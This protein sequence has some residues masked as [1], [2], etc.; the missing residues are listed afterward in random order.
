MNNLDRVRKLPWRRLLA[1]L[2][3]M[4]LRSQPA[5][6]AVQDEDASA[7]R[8]VSTWGGSASA[9][10]SPGDSRDMAEL[11]MFVGESRVFPAPGVAR[12]AVGSGAILTAAAMDGKDV[13]LFANATGS[14]TLFIWSEN[15]INQKIKVTVTAGDITRVARDIS[16]FVSG[17]PKVRTSIIGDKVIIEG[18]DLSD[19]DLSKIDALA[20]MYPQVVN[21]TNKL[22]WEQMVLLDVKVVEFPVN[23]LREIGMKW[24]STGGAA[25]AGIWSPFRRG[26]DGPYQINIP[27]GEAGAPVS[28][29]QGGGA[30]VILT[31]RLNILSGIN[32]GI[33]AELNLLA[34]EGQASILSEP[35]LSA[36]NG[37]EAT[38]LAGGELP[39]TVSTINGPTVLFKP[40]GIRLAI[41]PRVSPSGSI[42][43]TIDSEVSSIDNSISTSSGPALLTR[44]TKTEFNVLNGETIVLSGLISREQNK[45]VDKLP[46]LGD[47]PVIGALFRSKR[48]QNKET[49]LV[50]FV[51][52][53][54]IDSKT[55]ELVDRVQRTEER[56]T[57]R[58]GPPPHLSDPLQT[59]KAVMGE[60]QP[61]KAEATE[62][63]LEAERNQQAQQG[64][65]ERESPPIAA[66][67][68]E[69]RVSYR[70]LESGL[71]LHEAA[72]VDAPISRFLKKGTRLTAIEGDEHGGWLRVTVVESGSS[73]SGWVDR[74][75]VSRIDEDLAHD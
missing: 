25:V 14:T 15:R 58:L 32:L 57:R 63:Q 54:L 49:E 28:S 74:R 65:A 21:F 70:V 52:P 35:Q 6:S 16:A 64:S 22:G 47:L 23:K 46:L 40:Y 30:P 56:L 67:P 39:Y 8:P 5:L 62:V 3:A 33:Q 66:V 12:I 45:D 34:Q 38:F 17:M 48:F 29:P 71:L 11:Q 53:H 19:V 51:T 69:P 44:Q 20:K 7:G 42:R 68:P 55:P 73:L 24:S 31:D 13:I 43:A 4:A 61:Q 37:S 2:L 41:V 72:H 26:H 27:A 10:V 1:L 59:K 18:D 9:A 75:W 50:V 36:R 60:G